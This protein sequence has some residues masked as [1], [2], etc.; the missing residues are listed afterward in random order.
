MSRSTNA[1]AGGAASPS[2]AGSFGPLVAAGEW[3]RIITAG[4]LHAGLL[5]LAFNMLALWSLSTARGRLG[6]GRFLAVYFVSLLTGSL[7]VLLLSPERPH[8]RCLGRRVRA[9]GRRSSS[10]SGSAASTPVERHRRRDRDQPADH[11]HDP[12]IS[13]GG[14]LGGLVGGLVSAWI[15]LDLGPRLKQPP[16]APLAI[17]GAL[18]VAAFAACLVVAEAAVAG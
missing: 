11:V 5:H 1:V 16:W 13:I 10:P 18:G 12:R 6:R 4:F 9:H 3:W 15:L 8:R 14:H 17:V 7:G 2:T